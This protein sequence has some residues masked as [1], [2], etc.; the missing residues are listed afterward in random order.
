MA[1]D[2]SGRI[3]LAG[4]VEMNTKQSNSFDFG[5]VR[6]SGSG[7]LDTTFNGT[8]KVNTG[9][10]TLSDYAKAV[11]I[12][13]S[14]GKIIAAGSSVRSS[15][16]SATSFAVTRY[17]SNG[18]LDTTFSGDGKLTVALGSTGGANAVAIQADG[19]IVAAGYSGES[20]V[21]TT[22]IRLNADGNLD[23]T[24]GSGGVVVTALSPGG[25]N[26]RAVLI[27]SVGGA[28][29]I[30]AVGIAARTMSQ[31][32]IA[33]ARYNLD[34]TLD[35][36]FG[37]GGSGVVLTQIGPISSGATCAA[38]DAQGRIVVGGSDRVADGNGHF[39]LARFLPDGTL[40]TSLNGTGSVVT[41]MDTR[42][43][44]ISSIAIAPD[45]KIVTGGTNEGGNT[46]GTDYR[47][48][49]ACY[50]PDGSLDASFDGDGKV[51]TK[52]GTSGD[53]CTAVAVLGDGRIVAGGYAN[54]T[55][56]NKTSVD[57][58]AVRYNPDG[59]LDTT[60]G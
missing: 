46:P 47:F 7:A 4:E 45:G 19:K 30:L 32:Q 58:I 18:S 3:V 52:V 6:H 14:S 29:K 24:F 16:S 26:A 43:D 25:D 51:F 12:D 33:M 49:L 31:G 36:S 22:L 17:N 37:S 38:I 60:F 11:A 13:P 20:F 50:N 27:Q 2:S 21:D 10:S 9:V 44:Y 8:G 59:S 1:I 35:S 40:D 53:H 39:A 56:K 42:G 23:P 41:V 55:I 5:L 34:G 15:S 57:F 28:D 54:R 48:T